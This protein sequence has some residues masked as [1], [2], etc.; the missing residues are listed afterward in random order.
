MAP[1]GTRVIAHERPK[2][3]ATW[4]THG[5]DDLYIGPATEHYR[6]YKV[7]INKTYTV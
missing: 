3:G 4:D 1:P 6:C 5:L 7:D 2:Q